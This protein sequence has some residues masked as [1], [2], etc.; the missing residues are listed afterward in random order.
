MRTRAVL[1]IVS[2]F[3]MPII[4]MEAAH[5]QSDNAA[6][7]TK[8]FGCYGFVPTSD[9]GFGDFIY[10]GEPTRSVVTS[11]GNTT[12]TC[13]F[14]IP[15]GE[16]PS[17]ATQAQGFYCGTFLGVTNDTRMVATP[18]GTATLTCQINRNNPALF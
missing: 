7:I 17:S 10:S 15:A 1:A 2:L 9:G 13:H 18:G 11:S 6:Q 12:L 4:P 16:Q 14:N 3:S 8:D 5:A